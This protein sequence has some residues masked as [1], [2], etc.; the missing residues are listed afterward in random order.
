MMQFAVPSQSLRGTAFCVSVEI[1]DRGK[2]VA[3][4]VAA[5]RTTT[6]TYERLAASG[7]LRLPLRQATPFANWPPAGWGAAPQGTVR[8]LLD[9]DREDSN[10]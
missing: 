9:A 7:G 6:S 4:L 1:T 5:P 10:Q 8:E 2:V 3:H